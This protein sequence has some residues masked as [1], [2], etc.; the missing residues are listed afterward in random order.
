MTTFKD[1]IFMNVYMVIRPESTDLP[2]IRRYDTKIFKNDTDIR[3]SWREYRNGE[4][5]NYMGMYDVPIDLQEFGNYAILDIGKT[6]D[7]PAY[8]KYPSGKYVIE[9]KGGWSEQYYRDIKEIP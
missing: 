9:S 4:L 5:I 8:M 1:E 7:V 2:E 3:S 6:K